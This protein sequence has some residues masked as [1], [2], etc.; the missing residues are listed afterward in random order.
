MIGR[1]DYLLS[2]GVDKEQII[3]VNLED[4]KYNL[5]NNYMDLL[6]KEAEENSWN[7][8]ADDI[9]NLLKSVEK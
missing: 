1:K 9:V 5:I 4:L 2:D 7:S 6:K 8:K 3:S